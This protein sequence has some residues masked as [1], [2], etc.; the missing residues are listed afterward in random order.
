[1]P[2]DVQLGEG[3]CGDALMSGFPNEYRSIDGDDQTAY[4]VSQHPQTHFVPSLPP[5]NWQ[6]GQAPG[7]QPVVRTDPDNGRSYQVQ[8]IPGMG[9]VAMPAGAPL[10]HQSYIHGQRGVGAVVP[11]SQPMADW[12][13][14]PFSGMAGIAEALASL[15]AGPE[16]DK[17]N[18][19]VR[20]YH[21]KIVEAYKTLDQVESQQTQA[22]NLLQSDLM[23]S[24]TP[25]MGFSFVQ[26]VRWAASLP[27]GVQALSA[28]AAAKEGYNGLTA[29]DYMTTQMALAFRPVSNQL[30]KVYTGF[31][32]LLQA[33]ANWNDTWIRRVADKDGQRDLKAAMV[34]EHNRLWAEAKGG[35]PR[36]P[37]DPAFLQT[38]A[39]AVAN[40]LGIE[41][42]KEKVA[43]SDMSG[44]G[45][46]GVVEL[47]I[48]A[49]LVAA[50]TAISVIS[51]VVGAIIIAKEFNA[52]ANNLYE[53][54]R[55]YEEEMAARREEYVYGRKAEGVPT[56]Q[57]EQEWTAIKQEEDAKQKEKEEEYESKAG[58]SLGKA[59]VA[60][61]LA[62]GAAIVLSNVL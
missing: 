53:M 22:A 23:R 30:G 4:Q 41:S 10:V 25:T 39:Q 57:A 48:S 56:A 12:R 42:L 8:E 54:R 5:G 40:V 50:L 45:D 61:G 26:V 27:M 1:M 19:T 46:L 24:L 29:F 37:N 60:G 34:A 47:G 7:A 3:Y 62:V 15:V 38:A 6:R 14:T 36:D 52:K 13:G 18:R 59:L 31:E 58:M 9:K 17:V 32:G 21:D 49:V 43:A 35:A 44:M 20:E 55:T 11:V 2:K 28:M 33:M 51:I 16:L